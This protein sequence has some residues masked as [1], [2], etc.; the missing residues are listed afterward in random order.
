MTRKQY[1]IFSYTKMS[2]SFMF[3]IIA[4]IQKKRPTLVVGFSFSTELCSNPGVRAESALA[5]GEYVLTADNAY[6]SAVI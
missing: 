2:K 4:H 1:A 3:N 6:R 5:I